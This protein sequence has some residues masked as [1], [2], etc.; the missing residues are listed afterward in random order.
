MLWAWQCVHAHVPRW[1]VGN[2]SCRSVFGCSVCCWATQANMSDVGG[3]EQTAAVV[4][5]RPA[6]VDTLPTLK[7]AREVLKR[8]LKATTKE[9]KNEAWHLFKSSRSV[10][11]KVLLSGAEAQQVDAKSREAFRFWPCLV[12]ATQ[13]VSGWVKG[14]FLFFAP[15]LKLVAAWERLVDNNVKRSIRCWWLQRCDWQPIAPAGASLLGRQFLILVEDMQA[16]GH[17][18]HSL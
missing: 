1:H 16:T 14:I 4:A 8:Q 7:A 18:G 3:Q 11:L 2:N 15:A 6:P 12:T 10:A 13:S 17:Q 5:A 9:I